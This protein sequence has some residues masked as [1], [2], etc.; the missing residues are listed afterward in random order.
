MNRRDSLVAF[1][2][3]DLERF[4]AL[5]QDRK[6]LVVGDLLLDHHLWGKAE[7]ISPEAPVPVV[8]VGGEENS[9]GGAGNVARNLR[10]IGCQV[11][12][13][14]VVGIDEASNRLGELLEEAGIE[15]I[16]Q[17]DPERITA[18][19]TRILAGGQQILRVDQE[20]SRPPPPGIEGEF[21]RQVEA[22]LDWAEAVF[23]SN[24]QKGAITPLLL[25]SLLPARPDLPVYVDPRGRDLSRYRGATL[26][27]PNLREASLAA[28]QEIVDDASLS[29]AGRRL[30]EESDPELLLI[31]R[32]GRGMSLFLKNGKRI[33]VA[34]AEQNV[35]DVTGAGDTVLAFAGLGHSCGLGF[36]QAARLATEAAGIVVQKLGA[37]AVEARELEEAFGLPRTSDKEV[38][39]GEAAALIRLAR[40][41]GQTVVFTNGCFDLLHV[42]HIHLLRQA[43]ELG[44]LLVIGLN[45][46]RSIREIKG[47]LRPLI[48]QHERSHMLASIDA[49]DL[50][51]L[52]DESTPVELLRQLQPDILVKGA[53]YTRD[54]VVGGD[55]VEA[56]G[57]RIELIDLKEGRSTSKIIQNILE[58]YG[59]PRRGQ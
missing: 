26:I 11:R 29:Q 3:A 22:Q 38:T 59:T 49:V 32:G 25:K 48:S 12:L 4:L 28:G 2:A 20:S 55:I 27:K 36:P 51:V 18:K 31:T 17:E 23:I 9:L 24:Y 56:N 14:S 39:P 15:A 1:G 46:D 5:A 10:T 52:F 33:D 13:C 30:L 57:G 37:A 45:T 50:V 8:R 19:K 53:D 7:R 34:A 21:I 42:G 6:T 41:Q 44:D 16:L 58:R 47:P 43:R 40:R 54:A 35:F